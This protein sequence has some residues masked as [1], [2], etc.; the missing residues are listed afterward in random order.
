M[1]W[2]ESVLKFIVWHSSKSP[3]KHDEGDTGGCG[4]WR[5]TQ[6]CW[7]VSVDGSSVAHSMHAGICCRANRDLIKCHC[8]EWIYI[9]VCKPFYVCVRKRT[10]LTSCFVVVNKSQRSLLLQGCWF[11]ETFLENLLSSV[12]KLQPAAWKQ[13]SSWTHSLQSYHLTTNTTKTN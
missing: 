2:N 9:Y 13:G 12:Q 4:R 8:S 7:W 6:L 1:L 10:D 11:K 3:L 5:R